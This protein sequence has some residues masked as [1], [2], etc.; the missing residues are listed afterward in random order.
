MKSA[1]QYVILFG[2]MLLLSTAVVAG[3][4]FMKPDL[5]S[6][7][8][9]DQKGGAPGTEAATAQAVPLRSVAGPTLAELQG[10]TDSGAKAARDSVVR[11]QDSLQVLAAM[12]Q[13]ERQKSEALSQQKPVVVQ[14]TTHPAVDSAKVKQRKNMAKVL[15]SMP[16]ENAARILQ[17]LPEP[18]MKELLMN[19]KKRQAAK[20]LSAIEPSRASKLFR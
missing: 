17:D 14:D 4:M 3:L 9:P 6:G 13:H 10:N 18:E 16:A 19:V 11:L 12:L 15:E 20:I 2:I 8:N 1:G 7:S 5:F